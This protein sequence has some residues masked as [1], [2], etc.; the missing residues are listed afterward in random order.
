MGR[1]ICPISLLMQKGMCN[2]STKKNFLARAQALLLAAVLT[3][4]LLPVSAFAAE[5]DLPQEVTP[6]V[7]QNA[8]VEYI[9]EELNVSTSS[10]DSAETGATDSLPSSTYS[11]Q[12]DAAPTTE[13]L[14]LMEAQSIEE[15]SPSPLAFSFYDVSTTKTTSLELR[16]AEDGTYTLY[17]P[18]SGVVDRNHCI[19]IIAP[20]S[21]TEIFSLKY[22]CYVP[23]AHKMAPSPWEAKSEEGILTAEAYSVGSAPSLGETEL[24]F[25]RSM[26]LYVDGAAYNISVQPYCDLETVEVR[27]SGRLPAYRLDAKRPCEEI[28]Q[29]KYYATAPTGKTITVQPSVNS[30]IRA[31]GGYASVDGTDGQNAYRINEKTTVTIVSICN[32]EWGVEDRTYTLLLAPIEEDYFPELTDSEGKPVKARSIQKS[33]NIGDNTSVT[34]MASAPG[35]DLQWTHG[36]KI[37]STT[38]T[39]KIDTTNPANKLQNKYIF[40]A[41]VVVDGL[42]YTST[43]SVLAA[44]AGTALKDP[45]ITS[46]PVSATYET[47]SKASPLCVVAEGAA[48]GKLSYTWYKNTKCSTDGAEPVENKSVNQ[49][50]YIP[51]T[52]TG[53][54]YYYY[55]V[56][57]DTYGAGKRK[58]TSNKVTSDIVRVEVTGGMPEG[59]TGSGT[60]K[61]PY[62]FSTGAQLAALQNLVANGD[63]K[64]FRNTYFKFANDIELPQDWKPLGSLKEGAALPDR[65]V[66]IN[67]FSGIIDGDGHKIIIPKGGLP[68]IGYARDAVVKNLN[69]YG[70]EINGYGL[71][72]NYV[73]DYGD[74]G[75][76]N[77]GDVPETIRIENCRLLKGSSTLKSGFIGG[78]ASGKNYV[79]IIDCT[80][81]EGVTIGYTGDESSIGSFGGEFNGMLINCT[82]SA[83]VKGKNRVGGLVGNKGQS[84][85]LFQIQNCS[86]T[87]TVIATGNYVGGILGSGYNAWSAPNSPLATV[88]NC[89]VSGSITGADKIGGITGGEPGVVQAWGNGA[90]DIVD[91]VFYG[92]ITATGEGKFV[93]GVIGYMQSLN[94][95][96]WVSDNYYCEDSGAAKGIGEIAI[97]DTSAEHETDSNTRYVNTA[98]EVPDILGFDRRGG[99]NRTDDPVG[100]DADKLVKRVTKEDLTNETVVALLNSSKTSFRNWIQGA[101]GPILRQE[102][103]AYELVVGGEIKN[104]HYVGDALNLS[105]LTLTAKWSD[106]TTTNV[107]LNDPDLKI[108]GYDG[109]K[110]GQQTVTLQYGAAKVEIVVTVLYKEPEDI[111]VTITLLGDKAHGDN[112][113][114]HGLSKGG[115]TAWVSGHKVE[116]TTNMTV[117]DALKQLPDVTW[118]NPTGNYIKS[119][120][121]GGV[122]IGEFTNGKNS[123]WMYTLNGKYPMLGVSEQYL[124]KGDVIVFHYTDDYTLEAADMG[125]APEE[126]KTADEVIALINAIG[127]VDLT[128]GDVIAKARAAYDALSAAD[129]KLV[130]NYQTLLDA[131]AAYAKLVAELGK[132]ADTIYKNT[133]DYLAKRGTPSVGSIGGEWMALGLARSGRTVPEGYYDAVV[134]YVKDNIDSNGRL[135]KNKATENARIILALTAIG[136]DVTNVDGHDLLAGL[137]E[138]SY[139]SKQGINGAIFTLIAL[140]SH[141]YTPAGDVTRDKLVQVI[142]D[143]QISSDGGWSLDG[144][145]ADVDMTAMAIQALAAY[146]KSNS[147]A[148][149]AVDKGLSWLS[150]VQQNDG[151][152]TSWGAA[153]SESCAQ[154]IV[155][156][157]ALG[158][159][160]AKDSRFIKNGAS[161]LDALCSFAVDGGGFK[162]LAT[163]TSAN[164]MATEQGF[165]ALVA[166]YRLLNGQSSLYDMADVKLEGVKT[167]ESV[168]DADKPDD[169]TNT[170][171]PVDTEVEDTSSGGQVVLWVVIGAVAVGGITALAVTSKKR[172]GRG[173]E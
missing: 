80:I 132:K 45:V 19:K 102:A 67:A 79:Y 37:V 31:L 43:V 18:V 71:L 7:G 123:G 25:S 72:N 21:Y 39:V 85:G 8:E 68:L 92:T 100:K 60:E 107:P 167:E 145:N 36:G 96:N 153:N 17:I 58:I 44:V 66:N 29:F 77:V 14:A 99:Y 158:I 143:A 101:T 133:G 54:I 154:V 117:W 32:E 73:V 137:N 140:D 42:R 63:G 141:S 119:V 4:S 151:G 69:I 5:N 3:L 114:V 170:D 161:V 51:D 38:N 11:K 157:T 64:P 20:E 135:D 116:V 84:M 172:H 93:G 50:E 130:T 91:N 108:T 75:D 2:M 131:E 1:E 115:L 9:G 160:P 159:N 149:K 122:T 28:E 15:T 56:V 49:N 136:K 124:K 109:G 86:F 47:G 24:M 41:S 23:G 144:K 27:E 78:Y 155:A 105:G 97:V 113:Q 48:G 70:E 104:Q 95:N 26:Q 106:G 82:S 118:D 53:G 134:K 128:K 112:G 110:H 120:T 111:T 90:G 156:L 94:K 34:V 171:T 89:F 81:E 74:N 165:Y 139:L 12:E 76:Y 129:K 52:G 127:V 83:T 61:D 162:H 126:K 148:K 147:S 121:Y 146:Y 10:E 142:L 166:Y 33:A 62:I 169:A 46:Q 40:E 13:T 88:R 35:A 164:G 65:G 103:V 22:D 152:F 163:E 16:Q 6:S 173:A 138:M 87:G 57:Q 98:I 59:V 55:C 30:N 168:N 150:S 125:P